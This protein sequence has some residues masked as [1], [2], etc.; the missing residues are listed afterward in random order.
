MLGTVLGNPLVEILLLA[1]SH[2]SMYAFVLMSTFSIWRIPLTLQ[3]ITLTYN[4]MMFRAA[5]SRTL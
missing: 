3:I 5:T 1:D 4:N 2:I